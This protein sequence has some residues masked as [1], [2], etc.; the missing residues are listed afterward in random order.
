M[1][2][3]LGSALQITAPSP[4]TVEREYE[5][6]IRGPVGAVTDYFGTVDK[7]RMGQQFVKAIAGI[8]EPQ[9]SFPSEFG[10]VQ[11]GS[12]SV[13]LAADAGDEAGV[14]ARLYA[15]PAAW[16][17]QLVD[18]ELL[19]RIYREDGSS[20]EI[21]NERRCIIKKTT[22]R[23]NALTLDMADV[24]R[25]QLDTLFPFR[26]YTL[27]DWPELYTEHVNKAVPQGVGTLIKVPLAYLAK[28][29]GAWKY[30]A[31][32]VVGATPTVLAVYRAGRVVPSS[33]YAVSTQVV[34]GATHLLI[35]FSREQLDFSGNLYAM[36]ADL[37]CPGSR[38]PADELARLMILGGCSIDATSFTLAALY[39]NAVGILGDY[40][41]VTQRKLNAIVEDI[42]QLA[43][44]QLYRSPAGAFGLFVDRPREVRASL[45]DQT[46]ECAL[47]E[48]VECPELTKAITL[49]YRPLTSAGDASGTNGQGR[50]TRNTTGATGEKLYSNPYIRDHK[51]ADMHNC[52]LYKLEKNRAEARG[53]VHAVQLRVGDLMAITSQVVFNGAKIFAAPGINRPADRN[54]VTLRQYVED[55]YVYDAL[56]LPADPTN[57]YAVD[58]SQ[59][60]PSAPASISV[61][62]KTSFE[63]D[64]AWATVVPPSGAAA[65]D[66]YIVENSVASGA[67]TEVFR[68]Q[69]NAFKRT[70]V[71]NG[72]TYQFRV[73][74]VD[75]NGQASAYTTSSSITPGPKIDDSH[76][77]PAA[78]TGSS[79]ANGAINQ[80]R[81]FTGTSSSSANVPAAAGGSYGGTAFVM[82]VYTFFP[83]I[84]K[85]NSA[86][87][88]VLLGPLSNKPG[89]IDG[90]GFAV[91]NA[92]TAFICAVTVTWRKFSP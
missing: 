90:G 89:A 19:T 53:T 74:A 26:L 16:R 24:D 73:K 5:A 60:P 77:I 71:T 62:Q 17:E 34:G 7:Y 42:L 49:Q 8:P 29:G 78:V 58:Y 87:D 37:S 85:A 31:C 88:N 40:G 91:R 11:S 55:T 68:G 83:D 3:L 14:Y 72:S 46:D 86:A 13:T 20:V 69:V 50:I 52:Y 41:Y 67:F 51:V 12:V 48:Y 10:I 64:V 81:S 56:T 1:L 28:S 4:L 54:D 63:L 75:I 76:I 33:E 84:D 44:G 32:E 45:D 43:R 22:R 65:I 21:T 15:L 82:D 70:N 30:G 23:Q 9:D 27:T 61:A 80:G 36:T 66:Y 35:T 2:A 39:H 6:Y 59:T 57:G 92:D 25:A 47:S 18:L 38:L 79:I